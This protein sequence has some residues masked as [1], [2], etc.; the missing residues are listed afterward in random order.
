MKVVTKSIPSF[1]ICPRH[2]PSDLSEL[3]LQF[4]NGMEINFSCTRDK[5]VLIIELQD[6]TMLEQR[7][8]YEFT[9]LDNQEIIYKGSIIFLKDGTDI[10]NY[11]N[12]SQDNTPW[13]E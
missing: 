12:Q 13:K 3:V 9:L 2:Y 1:S 5:N 10:Q 8:D 11:T 7:E 4:K 6:T